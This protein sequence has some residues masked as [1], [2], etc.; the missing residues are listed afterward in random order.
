[1]DINR[2]GAP[3]SVMVAR[4][5][6]SRVTGRCA[7]LPAFPSLFLTPCFCLLQFLDA[8]GEW[9]YDQATRELFI[10]PPQEF[11]APTAAK[12]NAAEV[13]LTQTDTLFE[14]VGSSSDSGSRVENIIFAN[15]SFSHTSSQFFRPH[16]ETSGGDYSTHRSGAVKVENATG[17]AFTGSNFSWI[18]G[19]GVVLSASVRGVNV[20]SSVFRFLGTSGV[21]V[22]GKTGDAMMDGRDGERMAAVHGPAADNGVRYPT[23]NLVVGNVFADYGIWD[24]QSACFHK[25]LAPDNVFKNNVCF[26]ASRHGVNFQDGVGGSIA[27]GNVMFNLNR[28]TSDTTAFNSWSRRHYVTSH[29]DDPAVATLIPSRYNQWR[30]NLIL[31]RNYYGVR[32]GN[33]DGL[34]NDDGASFYTHSNNVLYKVG[35][36]FN[37]GTQ[38]HAIGNLFVAGGGWQMGPTPDVASAFNNTFVETSNVLSGSC[39]GFFQKPAHKGQGN[40]PG[41]YTGDF[42]VRIA[43]TTSQSVGPMA[44]CGINLT[45]WQADTR[46]QDTHSHAINASDFGYTPRKIVAL[47]KSMLY[48]DCF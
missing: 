42:N 14:F 36:T 28:E 29:A 41:I 20:S 48:A 15:L 7:T 27:E 17:L 8:P 44:F 34:R 25:A 40:T 35:I 2:P 23:G 30:R 1:M 43:G 24:K 26:N 33:G 39:T 11:T 37:G 19:N 12:L 22:Q 38:I 13:L 3:P 31:G 18:G 10:I 16:E 47:A 21:V 5:T 6:T 46:G 9:H 45:A 4:A 32:D